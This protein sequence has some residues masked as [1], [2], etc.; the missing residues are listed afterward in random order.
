MRRDI[1]I[2]NINKD[3]LVTVNAKTAA[4]KAPGGMKFFITDILTSN[5]FFNLELDKPASNLSGYPLPKESASDYVLTLR[6]VKPNNETK[7]VIAELIEEGKDFF[8]AD[9]PK[10]CTNLL[11]SYTC[12]L[13]IDAMVTV[14]EEEPPAEDEEDIESQE[15]TEQHERSTTDS[16]T[17]EV[18]ESIFTQI[19]EI[20]EGDPNYPLFIDSLATKDYVHKTVENMD[21]YGYAT[22]DY[23]NQVL[24]GGEIDLSEYVKEE[25]LNKALENLINFG[26]INLDKYVTDQEL[27]DA[28]ANIDIPDIDLSD[29]VTESELAKALVDV[30]TSGEVDL[31]SYATKEEL[32][33]KADEEHTHDNTYATY[34]F[35]ADHY[36][37][38]NDIPTTLPANGGNA[39]N[40]NTVCN[41]SI[42]VGTLTEY[43]SLTEITENMLYFIKDDE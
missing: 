10:S 27:A 15:I 6:I 43:L 25:E 2:K 31:S 30:M 36:A 11:G 29:Y 23:V 7:E 33:S 18:V 12:E 39:D 9:L 24:I 4:M 32:E 5:I 3:Y 8:V 21:L 42:W 1:D 38:K 16:F 13:F 14:G 35:L 22:R 28:L 26:D 17:Y 37:N 19:D 20:I 41:Y 40:A 34:E